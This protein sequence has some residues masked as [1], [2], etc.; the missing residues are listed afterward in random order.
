[1]RGM[2]RAVPITPEETVE[3]MRLAQEAQDAAHGDSNDA[4]IDALRD[5]LE[6]ALNLLGLALPDGNEPD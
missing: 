5:A 3:V 6:Y 4:E 1:M 2:L